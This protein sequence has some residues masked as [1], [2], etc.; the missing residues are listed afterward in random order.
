MK[1]EIDL[2]PDVYERIRVAARNES[3]SI[4][5]VIAR[6][7]HCPT[8][9]PRPCESIIGRYASEADLIRKV[10]DA[11]MADRERMPMRFP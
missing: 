1:V 8:F 4:G 10:S 6:L 9:S 2:D 3:L 11:A 7:L 5:E